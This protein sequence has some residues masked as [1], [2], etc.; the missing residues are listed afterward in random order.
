V[1][2]E[3]TFLTLLHLKGKTELDAFTTIYLKIPKY[4]DVEER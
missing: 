1:Q 3:P 2:L 4:L